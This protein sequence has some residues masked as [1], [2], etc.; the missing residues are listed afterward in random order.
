MARGQSQEVFPLC[1]DAFRNLLV[2]VGGGHVADLKQEA[3]RTGSPGEPEDFLGENGECSL[4]L[5]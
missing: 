5:Q 1:P 3:A 2:Q 4:R